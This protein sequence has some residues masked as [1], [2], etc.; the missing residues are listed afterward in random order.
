MA[1]TTAKK[2]ERAWT[3]WE[4]VCDKHKTNPCR[5]ERDVREFP[6]RNSFLLAVL[7]MYAFAVCKPKSKAKSFIKPSSALSYPLAIIRVFGRW[8]IH[9]PGFKQLKHALNGMRRQYLAFHGPDSL[10][11]TRAEN[12]KFCM[13]R[14]M[15]LLATDG[16]ML[17]DHMSL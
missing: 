3:F 6:A 10:A 7:M 2:D 11:P 12:M 8:G 15:R 17:L 13:V 5:T 1:P 16:S 4:H 14:A 9:M